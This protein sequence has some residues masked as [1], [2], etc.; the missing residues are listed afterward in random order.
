MRTLVHLA[1]ATLLWGLSSA[2]LAQNTDWDSAES[3]LSAE[4]AP[5][6]GRDP[7]ALDPN[8]EETGADATEEGEGSEGSEASAPLL[9]LGD[10][11][12]GGQLA[13]WA[14]VAFFA[15][16]MEQG[17]EG[18]SALA[19]SPLIGAAYSITSRARLSAQW[20]FT[21]AS[22][23]GFS[24]LGLGSDSTFRL[25]NPLLSADLMGARNSLRYRVGVGLALPVARAGD[26]T[27][28][29][30]IGLAMAM[31]GALHPW[32][33]MADRLSLVG[34]GRVE[35]DLGEDFVV[36]GDV[37]LGLLVATG[38]GG[39]TNLALEAG[40]DGEYHAAG[41]LYVG[42][43]LTMVLYADLAPALSPTDDD[44]LQFALMPYARFLFGHSFVTAGFEI[45][46]DPPFGSSFSN[47]GVWGLRVGVGTVL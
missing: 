5:N 10:T 38:G 19:T 26:R 23:D 33:W 6:E 41:P 31:R 13:L 15:G 2:A 28:D 34:S 47:S 20:G 44:N 7:G 40:G 4:D 18:T 1:L 32:L 35:S 24:T 39:N 17:G 30:G 37:A 29:L 36:G 9:E 3:N 14:E 46:I 16:D 11:E 42:V 22:H 25:G 27:E 8:T 21:F 43:R 12:G 45:N